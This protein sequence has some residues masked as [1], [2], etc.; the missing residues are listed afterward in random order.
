MNFSSFTDPMSVDGSVAPMSAQNSPHPHSPAPSSAAAD[1]SQNNSSATA[2]TFSGKLNSL[3]NRE[4]AGLGI[5][6]EEASEVQH[7][8]VS[9]RLPGASVI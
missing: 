4:P 3:A 8:S 5:L 9:T 1:S 6:K 7:K 2:H